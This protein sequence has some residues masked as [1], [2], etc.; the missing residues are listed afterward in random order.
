[1]NCVFLLLFCFSLYLLFKVSPLQFNFAFVLHEFHIWI[2]LRW[3]TVILIA[4]IHFDINSFKTTKHQPTQEQFL[5]FDSLCRFP[6]NFS[7][8][9]F[10]LAA[11]FLWMLLWLLL[12]YIVLLLLLGMPLTFSKVHG[13]VYF[14]NS[15]WNLIGEIVAIFRKIFICITYSESLLFIL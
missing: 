9:F 15:S 6:F 4:F 12:F 10:Y 2:Q 8:Y 13:S 11:K 1:M 7:T 14:I 5:F 3:Y